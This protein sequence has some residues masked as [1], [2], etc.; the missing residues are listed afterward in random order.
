MRVVIAT[1]ADGDDA[2]GYERS[3]RDDFGSSADSMSAGTIGAQGEPHAGIP[4]SSPGSPSTR[5]TTPGT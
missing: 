4:S 1:F 3:L 5:R 2:R